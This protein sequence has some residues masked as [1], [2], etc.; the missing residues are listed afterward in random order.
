VSS[1]PI[2]LTAT[3][4]PPASYSTGTVIETLPATVTGVVS[5][6]ETGTWSD[7]VTQTSRPTPPWPGTAR[8][9]TSQWSSRVPGTVAAGSSTPVV[10]TLAV[11][12]SKQLPT[13]LPVTVTDI[14][15]TGLTYVAG[16]ATVDRRRRARPAS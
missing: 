14:V 4:T 6:T 2:A 10:Y 15:P 1:V 3:G 9:L 16:S 12:N 8:G 5:F 13:T 7:A 11:T